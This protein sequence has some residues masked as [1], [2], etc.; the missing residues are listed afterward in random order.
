M[1]STLSGVE[2]ELT[3]ESKPARDR[4]RSVAESK[5]L[6]SPAGLRDS[7]GSKKR[8]RKVRKRDGR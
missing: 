8:G 6:G 3:E 2:A 7:R 4:D 1:L 5:G